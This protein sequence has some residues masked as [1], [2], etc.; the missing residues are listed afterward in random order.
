[1]DYS[2]ICEVYSR[3]ESTTK[4]LEKTD[5]LADFLEKIRKEP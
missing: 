1:M 2:K 3:L 5:I 4:G